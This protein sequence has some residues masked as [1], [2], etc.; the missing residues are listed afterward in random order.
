MTMFMTQ[1]NWRRGYERCR[2]YRMLTEQQ[3][4]AAVVDGSNVYRKKKKA[5]K[6]KQMFDRS[7]LR[8]LGSHVFMQGSLKDID[9]VTVA[10]TRYCCRRLSVKGILSPETASR[11]QM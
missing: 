3:R 5:T 4:A 2:D 9:T 6:T 10:S 8:I 1:S 11:L 7:H